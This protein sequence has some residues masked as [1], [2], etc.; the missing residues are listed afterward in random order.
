MFATHAVSRQ[1]ESDNG[2]PYNSREFAGFAKTEGFH[3]HRVTPEHA[4]ANGEAES[5]M[6]LLIKTEQIT[7]LKGG[8]SSMAFKKC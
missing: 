6:K 8:N 4:R 2:P 5:F 1:L 7:H 3:H